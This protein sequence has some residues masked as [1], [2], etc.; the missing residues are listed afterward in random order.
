MLEKNCGVY[1]ITCMPTGK[2]Y[3]GSSNRISKRWSRHRSSLNAGTH[4]NRYLQNSWNKYGYA[5]FEWA[6]L[7]AV[8]EESNLIAREQ[9]WMDVIHPELNLA[10]NA[11]PTRLGATNTEEQNKHI[12]E[13]NARQWANMTPDERA[14]RSRK[15][16]E[17]RGEPSDETRAKM[18]ESR[19]KFVREHPTKRKPKSELA[20]RK[21]YLYKRRLHTPEW[22]AGRAGREAVRVE[23]V[24]QSNLGRKRTEE[25]KQ[26]TRD[27]ANAMW[28][29]PEY[30]A[31]H[32]AATLAAM[33]NPEA[34]RKLSESH[35]G[36]VMSEEQK[37][38]IRESNT[39]RK[40]SPETKARLSEARKRMWAEKRANGTA[41]AI[42][43]KIADSK[44][45]QTQSEET[46][47]KKRLAQQERRARERLTDD[48]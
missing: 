10:D 33:Q 5:A 30:R 13:G 2:K 48:T 8:D 6:V 23:K 43:K 21:R 14:E 26:K 12:S 41:D 18:R 29:D 9:H 28:A 7:E 38:K 31:K 17:A 20:K 42:R 34:L 47:A 40:R 24:R 3:V 22:E 36:K 39:G 11:F 15:M 37:E 32:K 25:H 45:G 4:T 1:L 46:K 35:K 27:A 16:Q 19:N 44:R